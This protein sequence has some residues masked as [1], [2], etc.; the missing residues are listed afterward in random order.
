MEHL[1]ISVIVTTYNWPNA[2]ECVLSALMD[3][4]YPNFEI[5]IADDGSTVETF[6]VIKNWQ[7]KIRHPLHHCWQSD[8]GFRAAMCRNRAAAMARGDYLIFVDGDCIPLPNFVTRHAKLA[9]QGWF[10]AGNRV[11][12]SEPF[13]QEIFA[14]KLKVQNWPFIKW[15][16]AFAS[17][18]CNRFL[19]LCSLPLGLFRKGEAKRWQ[20]AKTCNLAVWRDDFI[21]VNGFDESFTGWGFEDSDFVIRLQRAKVLRKSGKF[22]AP[23][24]HLWHQSQ[25]KT[26]S[27]SNADRLTKTLQGTITRVLKGV[28]QYLHDNHQSSAVE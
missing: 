27:E 13:T 3:Q 2:L 23:V 12:L 17:S 19:P 10:V 16:K 28:D 14:N 8:E 24:L 22:A 26:E 1:S 11:L 21:R 4:D 25:D 7:T 18:K 9:E 20:G 5:I 6:D 15:F